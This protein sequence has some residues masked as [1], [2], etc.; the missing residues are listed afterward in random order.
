L[1]AAQEEG[2]VA[3]EARRTIEHAGFEVDRIKAQQRTEASSEKS[4]MPNSATDPR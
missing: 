3:Q 4:A 1:L 2:Q